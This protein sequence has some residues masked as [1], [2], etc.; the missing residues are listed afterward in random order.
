L[1]ILDMVWSVSSWLL[2]VYVR[3]VLPVA[4]CDMKLHSVTGW[5]CMAWCLLG[6]QFIAQQP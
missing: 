3:F 5:W 4:D 2:V 6:R 1:N